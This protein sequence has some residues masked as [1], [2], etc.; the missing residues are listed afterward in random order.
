MQDSF[1]H[2]T[3]LFEKNT[4]VPAACE[5]LKHSTHHKESKTDLEFSEYLLTEDSL[6]LI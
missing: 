3:V 1:A 5:A 6:D 2:V 4:V